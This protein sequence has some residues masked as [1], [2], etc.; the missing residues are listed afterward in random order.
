MVSYRV[1]GADVGVGVGVG[2]EVVS[3]QYGEYAV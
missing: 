3:L 1:T 2:V